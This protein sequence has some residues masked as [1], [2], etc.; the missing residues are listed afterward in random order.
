MARAARRAGSRTGAA[1]FTYVGLLIAIVILGIALSAVG[2]VWRTQAQREREQELLFIGRE[3]R[4]AIAKYYAAGPHQFP[5]DLGDLLEDKRSTE[6]RRYLRRMYVDPM[7]GAA[8][9]KVLRTDMLGITGIAS[10]SSTEPLKKKGFPPEEK[11]FEVAT[12]YC[13]WK[14]AYVP[15]INIRHRNTSVPPSAD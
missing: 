5:Q 3:F 1:G 2:T 4:S 8:D 10:S 12:C 11:E 9:W 6:P 7:T 14:F 13:D 15:R